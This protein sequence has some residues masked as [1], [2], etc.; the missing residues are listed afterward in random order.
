MTL[1]E[2]K[3]DVQSRKVYLLGMPQNADQASIIKSLT[4]AGAVERAYTIKNKLNL[5]SQTYG[6]AIFK[7]KE[8]AAKAILLKKFNHGSKYFIVKPFVSIKEQLKERESNTKPAPSAP[9]FNAA[10]LFALHQSTFLSSVVH[11]QMPITQFQH[12]MSAPFTYPPFP[13]HNINKMAPT[14]IYVGPM[15]PQGYPKVYAHQANV[16]QAKGAPV[17]AP[18]ELNL[19]MFA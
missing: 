2:Y 6:Y 14:A 8:F 1:N 9:H 19:K 3:D 10:E 4:K 16:A 12:Q 17:E 11:P 5:K 15:H 7:T 13:H 18:G